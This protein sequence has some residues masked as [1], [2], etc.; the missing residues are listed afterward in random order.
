MSY[1]T[2]QE[3]KQQI[4][5]ILTVSLFAHGMTKV[6]TKYLARACGMKPSTHFRDMLWELHDEGKI[7]FYAPDEV[8]HTRYYPAQSWYW[9]LSAIFN[10][11]HEKRVMDYYLQGGQ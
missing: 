3:R 2:R 6:S 9:S 11:D 5:E 10:Q 8:T 1:L 7:A 4:V